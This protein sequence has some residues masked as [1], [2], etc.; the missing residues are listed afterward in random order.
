MFKKKINPSHEY[1]PYIRAPRVTSKCMF[2][3]TPYFPW[4]K[5]SPCS[6]GLPLVHPK[7][8]PSQKHIKTLFLLV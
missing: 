1:M 4:D 5:H 8:R 7:V 3:T 2:L 6:Q